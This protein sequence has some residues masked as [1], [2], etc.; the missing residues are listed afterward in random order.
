MKVDATPVSVE[1]HVL[2]IEAGSSRLKYSMHINLHK[3]QQNVAD[4]EQLEPDGVN[5]SFKSAFQRKTPSK[6]SPK[7]KISPQ[8]KTRSERTSPRSQ[9]SATEPDTPAVPAW[10]A[11]SPKLP[12][13][14][15]GKRKKA[16]PSPW[17]VAAGAGAESTEIEAVG[18]VLDVLMQDRVAEMIAS[19]KEHGKMIRSAEKDIKETVAV[20]KQPPPKSESSKESFKMLSKN[21][22]AFTRAY[23]TMTLSALRAVEKAYEARKKA[24][25][26]IQKA[27]QVAKI[28]QERLER[29]EKIE[30][31]HRALRE[32][33]T[34]WKESE[35]SR[36]EQLREKKLAIRNEE[37]QQKS[38]SHHVTIINMQKQAEDKQFACNFN[39]QSTLVGAK[40]AREDRKMSQGTKLQE[41]KERVQQ[42]REVSQEHQEMVRRFMELRETKL[43]Q[44]GIS[45]KK[46]L[47][48]KL[49]QV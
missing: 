44:E 16:K 17:G 20:T 9:L 35:E 49:L 24:D 21:E 40:L 36:L 3:L 26:L 19:R 25:A 38:Q 33:A 27:N 22:M 2:G 43:L 29:R 13:V 15:E 46:E 45:A 5:K 31:F 6:S 12:T 34:L 28:K 10:V 47:D 7:A 1:T 18:Q 48:A 42:T 30:E 11:V 8:K 23:A 37:L 32:N 4:A 41:I 39:R 14:A